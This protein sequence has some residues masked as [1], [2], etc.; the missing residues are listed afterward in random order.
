MGSAFQIA[1]AVADSFSVAIAVTSPA[2]IRSLRSTLS[3]LRRSEGPARSGDGP[4]PRLDRLKGRFIL[5]WA[6]SDEQ[7]KHLQRTRGISGTMGREMT[8][9]SNLQMRSLSNVLA[10]V[11]VERT[12]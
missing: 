8:G 2:R 7:P 11:I 9:W 5:A 6:Q 10:P 3:P 1:S 4:E 12:G